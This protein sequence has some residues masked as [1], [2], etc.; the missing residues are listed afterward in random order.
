MAVY[1]NR[2]VNLV[3]PAHQ[4]NRTPELVTVAYADGTHENVPFGQVKYTKAEKDQLVK[5]YPSTYESVTVIDDEDLKAVRLGVTPPSDPE[6]KAMAEE[7]ARREKMQEETQKNVEKA[8]AE[9]DKRLEASLK[10]DKPVLKTAPAQV[11]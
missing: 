3:S 9:A 5:N 11:K 10:A 2:E 4:I 6:M 1:K 7:K 8:K